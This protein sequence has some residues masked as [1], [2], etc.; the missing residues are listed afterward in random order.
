[1]RFLFD[2]ALAKAP[3]ILVFDESEVLSGD[4]ENEAHRRLYR[5]LLVQI[6]NIDLLKVAVILLTN[7]PWLLSMLPTLSTV[8]CFIKSQTGASRLTNCIQSHR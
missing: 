5:E 6:S 7:Q 4:T 2:H 8:F 3:C 1:M